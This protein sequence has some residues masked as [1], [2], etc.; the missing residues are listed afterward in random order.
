MGSFK[1]KNASSNQPSCAAS[2]IV[3][4]LEDRRNTSPIKA[5]AEFLVIEHIERL[6]GN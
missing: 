2:P 5:D 1:R 4:T 6:M 3:V